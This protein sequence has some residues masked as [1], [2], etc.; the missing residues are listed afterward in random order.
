MRNVLRATNGNQGFFCQN[1]GS[2]QQKTTYVKN[3]EVKN[4]FWFLFA[5]GLSFKEKFHI[6][7]ISF[8]SYTKLISFLPNFEPP[9]MGL[10]GQGFQR[11]A[12]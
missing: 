8:P 11:F 3:R 7:P 4:T 6:S 2:S 9:A 10:C 5:P 1:L 12:L